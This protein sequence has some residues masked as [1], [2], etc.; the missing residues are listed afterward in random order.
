MKKLFYSGLLFSGLLF[1]AHESISGGILVTNNRLH[2]STASGKHTRDHDTKFSVM[3]SGKKVGGGSVR[4]N[5]ITQKADYAIFEFQ[6]DET[7]K[8]DIHMSSAKGALTTKKCTGL[9]AS[10]W[11]HIK[12]Q[13]LGVAWVCK[14]STYKGKTAFDKAVAKYKKK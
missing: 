13:T 8:F 5:S 14:S 7:G 12:A 9:D 2:T 1:T 11:Y 3:K 10:K 6:N 4:S